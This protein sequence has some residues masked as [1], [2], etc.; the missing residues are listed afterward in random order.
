[1]GVIIDADFKNI[2]D[3]SGKVAVILGA[4]CGIGLC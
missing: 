4:G 2:V 3:L 1:L